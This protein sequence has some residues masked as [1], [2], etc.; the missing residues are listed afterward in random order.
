MRPRFSNF[1]KTL[2]EWCLLI[3]GNEPST[4]KNSSE[5]AKQGSRVH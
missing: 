3:D 4:N 2:N 5:G 1:R